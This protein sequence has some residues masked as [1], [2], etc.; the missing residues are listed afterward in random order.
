MCITDF[1][2]MIL[3]CLN[4]RLLGER[5]C[6]HGAWLE[7]S[8]SLHGVSLHQS[9][10]VILLHTHLIYVMIIAW[11]IWCVITINLTWNLVFLNHLWKFAGFV[12]QKCLF[13]P[14]RS[15]GEKN[16]RVKHYQIRQTE[17]GEATFYLA[18]KYLFSTI[19]E[20]IHYH[21]HNA[22]GK[23]AASLSMKHE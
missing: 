4:A 15:N 14:F 13:L 22:A 16:P 19:P 7:T 18:E 6:I 23:C 9:T 2:W 12:A 11:Y 8:R 5:R 3:W 17:A 10:G 1:I 21:Q 20:L